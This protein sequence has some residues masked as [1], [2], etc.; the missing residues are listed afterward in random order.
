MRC[1]I[2]I[3]LLV[4]GLCWNAACEEP[5][6]PQGAKPGTFQFTLD[7]PALTSAGVYDAAGHLVRTLWSMKETKAGVNKASWDGLDE[8]GRP[9]PGGTFTWNVAVNGSTYRNVGTIGNTGKPPG[10]PQHVQHGVIDVCVDDKGNIYTANGW[11]EAG[12][13]FK[14]QGPDGQTLFHARYQ[15]RNGNPNGAPH[16]IAVDDKFIYCATHGWESEQW[17]NKMQ[18]Q[19]FHIEN[20]NHEKFTDPALEASAGHIQLYEWPKRQIPEGT[21]EEDAKLMALPVRSLKIVGDAIV[22]T[23]ALGGKIHKF[24]KV[25]GKKLGEFS[26][27]LPHAL[28]VGPQG[29]LWIGHQYSKVSVYTIDGKL[30][31]TKID[32]IGRIESLYFGPKGLLYVADGKAN[33]VKIYDVGNGAKLVRT[34]GGPAQPGDYAPDKFYR[35]VGAAV[36]S[37][38][39]IVTI[40]TLPTGGARIAR[41]S[42]DGACL[43][44]HLALMFCDVG[45]Y[46][47]SNPDEV[48]TQR[49]HR[50]ALTD[51]HNGGW[52]YRGT[53]LDGDPKYL[54]GNHGVLKLL[55]LGG[56]RFL[57]QCYGDSM[58]IYRRTP[59]GLYRMV[60]MVGSN[61]PGPDGRF[62]HNL[63]PEERKGDSWWSWTDQNA[64]GKIE[65][66]E[67]I[68]FKQ[69]GK[70]RYAMFGMNTDARGTLVF[71][72]HHTRAIWE[73]P[74]AGLDPGGNPVYDWRLV[75][76]IVPRDTSPVKFMPLMAIRAD[77]GSLYAFGRSEAWERPGGK[78]AGYA[79]M[80]GWALCRYGSN[81]ELLW[82][83]KLPN[84]C[85]GM[86]AIPARNGKPAGVMLGYFEKGYIYHYTPDGLLLGYMQVGEAA[87]KVTGWMDNTAAVAVNRDPR[88]GILDVFGEDSWLNRMIWYRVDDSGVRVLSGKINR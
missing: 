85:V 9:A 12:H 82:A 43:W 87:G 24:H 73:L 52:E 81:N 76:E 80:G 35:L 8:F 48:I 57:Y 50:I 46:S 33:Q 77:D 55:D 4:C 42:P 5:V 26:V 1:S 49:F 36:D 17:K 19:R 70:A 64:N 29:N 25:T 44:E 65:D 74:M 13:D 3:L 15:I 60:A 54:W 2:L 22:C 66:E 86:D 75:R 34:F 40:S 11:E 41:F 23:D 83:T 20:G 27:P 88:D 68:W 21:P 61:E 38:G 45:N 6:Q 72:E 59:A 10:E 67:V 62:V 14:V 7:K 47:Q 56:N 37:G 51:K 16:A 31:G 28:A 32:N 78:I 84:V 63:P 71:C 58:Q 79:W 30:L 69:P 39:N 53:V 18:I